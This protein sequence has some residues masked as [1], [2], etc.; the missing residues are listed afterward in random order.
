MAS[1]N[2]SDRPS[3]LRNQSEKK[4]AKRK[5]NAPK[6]KVAQH[7]LRIEMPSF[8]KTGKLLKPNDV[9]RKCF[10]C[11]ELGYWKRN[12]PKYLEG[13]KVKKAQGNV[14]LHSI[15]VLKLNYVDNSDNSWIVDSGALIIFVLLCR[16]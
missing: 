11:N 1:V 6:R 14:P 12:C 9:K 15:H 5:V 8:N 3:S 16:C 2:I 4:F 7:N 10:F 13:L